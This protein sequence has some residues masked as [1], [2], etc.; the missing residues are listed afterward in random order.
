VLN[1]LGKWSNKHYNS[2]HYD[3]VDSDDTYN[4][5]G[6]YFTIYFEEGIPKLYISSYKKLPYSN[7]HPIQEMVM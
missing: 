6:K 5:Y 7:V 2:Y 4:Y 1:L 3:M